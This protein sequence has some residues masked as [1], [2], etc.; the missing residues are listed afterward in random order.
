VKKVLSDLFVPHENARSNNT[1][2]MGRDFI[3]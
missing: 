3:G 1:T 2:R